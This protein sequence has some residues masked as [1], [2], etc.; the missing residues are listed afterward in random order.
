MRQEWTLNT[1]PVPLQ[2]KTIEVIA[3]GKSAVSTGGIRIQV[4]I[5]NWQQ[6]LFIPMTTSKSSWLA[7]AQQLQEK[8]IDLPVA[9][10][11]QE[12]LMQ[13][14]VILFA[15]VGS[16][17]WVDHLANQYWISSVLLQRLQ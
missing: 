11:S 5:G 16:L 13:E 10:D 17:F 7:I 14:L 1:L 4:D 3:S 12:E 2:L 6:I 8:V 9:T 15:Y